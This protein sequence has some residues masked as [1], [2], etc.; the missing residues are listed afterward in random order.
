M[1]AAFHMLASCD[2]LEEWI[3]RH[4][5]SSTRMCNECPEP[6]VTNS[7][8]MEFLVTLWIE[9]KCPVTHAVCDAL[10]QHQKAYRQELLPFLNWARKQLLDIDLIDEF[11]KSAKIPS[12]IQY[13]KLFC[14]L[15]WKKHLK[16]KLL[17]I[18]PDSSGTRV[19]QQAKLIQE[20]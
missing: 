20:H 5:A 12:K 11:A 19:F 7:Q 6:I 8:E 15:E 1:A 9:S 3:L 4:F 10:R 17:T 14:P 16:P 13:T 2:Q 18:A